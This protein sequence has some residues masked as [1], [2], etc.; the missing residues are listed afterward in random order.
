MGNTQFVFQ[1]R[2]VNGVA[3]YEFMLSVVEGKSGEGKF[4]IKVWDGDGVVYDNQMEDA[5]NA[6]PTTTIQG[7]SIVIHSGGQG[8]K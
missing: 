2:S 4:R 6:E 8:K 3:G 7:G 5:D 1:A